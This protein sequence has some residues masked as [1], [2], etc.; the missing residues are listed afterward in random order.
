MTSITQKWYNLKEYLTGPKID[1]TFSVNGQIN[2][3]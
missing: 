3:I 2:L 1:D